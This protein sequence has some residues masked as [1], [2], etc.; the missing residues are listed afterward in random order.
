MTITP[1]HLHYHDKYKRIEDFETNSKEYDLFISGYSEERMVRSVY[2]KINA[3]KKIWLIFPDYKLTS[4]PSEE[5]FSIDIEINNNYLESTFINKFFYHYSLND[6]IDKRICIDITGFIK[7]YIFSLLFLLKKENFKKIDIVYSEPK[8]YKNKEKTKFSSQIL[9]V[10]AINFFN[11]SNPDTSEDMLIINAG[12]DLNLITAVIEQYSGIKEKKLLLGSPPLMPDMLQENILNIE[13]I[14]NYIS[15]FN[16]L[17]SPANNPFETASI[18]SAYINK[19]VEKKRITNLYIAPLATKP[20]ALGLLFFLMA[21]KTNLE[22]KY[23]IKMK[24]VYPFTESYSSSAGKD[25]SQ[26]NIYNLD[27]DILSLIS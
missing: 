26:I 7:P 2:D 12:Y 19:F 21:E 8:Y 22:R 1:Y 9:N 14:R 16:P 5:N 11:S 15:N 6:F 17:F 20:Q 13:N 23:G 24:V 18:I 4:L 25:I 3:I 10:R 27:F